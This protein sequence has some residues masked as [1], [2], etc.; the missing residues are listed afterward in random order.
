MPVHKSYEFLFGQLNPTPFNR[1]YKTSNSGMIID[2]PAATMH[3]IQ[4]DTMQADMFRGVKIF[5]GVILAY[6]YENAEESDIFAFIRRLTKNPFAPDTRAHFFKVMV[7][8][9]HAHLVNPL[10]IADETEAAR[11]LSYYP[12]FSL[13]PTA[14]SL[15]NQLKPGSIVEVEFL[16]DTYTHGQIKS[17]IHVADDQDAPKQLKST[18]VIFRASD[19]PPGPPLL[20]GLPGMSDYNPADLP[21]TGP[22]VKIRSGVKITEVLAASLKMLGPW[23]P[24]GTDICSGVRSSAQQE[25]II[26]KYAQR[27]GVEVDPD[28]RESIE[29]A[30]VTLTDKSG[31]YGLY[32]GRVAYNPEAPHESHQGHFGGLAIDFT[33]GGG[34]PDA[35]ANIEAAVKTAQAALPTFNTTVILVEEANK[36]VH[37]NMDPSNTYNA[38]DLFIHWQTQ[39]GCTEDPNTFPIVSAAKAN[40]TM[41][42]PPDEMDPHSPEGVVPENSDQVTEDIQNVGVYEE[43][44]E[45]DNPFDYLEPY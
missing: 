9:L 31:P 12:D 18:L 1:R 23:L 34:T 2:S 40:Y 11:V 20:P 19:F 30:R 6:Y 14:A 45:T 36:C 26:V 43:L 21:C 8:E 13:N 24:D 5:K 38:D 22:A 27:L 17:V 4:K 16:D 10:I 29:A 32:I 3:R 33:Q 15:G 25:A 37:V 44:E 41:G 42:P 39:T 35:L 28:S 7:P